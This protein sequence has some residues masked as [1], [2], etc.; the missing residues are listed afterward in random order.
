[1]PP[2]RRAAEATAPSPVSGLS[3]GIGAIQFS[4][5]DSCSQGSVFV[6]SQGSILAGD[7]N[8]HSQD[9]FRSQS[10]SQ[11]YSQPEYF[12]GDFCTP[13]DQ[14]ADLGWSQEDGGAENAEP[15][16]STKSASKMCPPTPDVT[17]KRRKTRS[18]SPRRPRTS[19]FTYD[20]D[21][22]QE[23]EE[24]EED[25]ASDVKNEQQPRLLGGDTRRSK[26]EAAGKKSP[27]VAPSK[28]RGGTKKLQGK[29]NSRGVGS[30]LITAYMSQ[31]SVPA[32]AG[33]SSSPSG[34]EGDGMRDSLSPMGGALFGPKGSKE[35]REGCRRLSASGTKIG[36]KACRRNP[37]LAC[38]L[39]EKERK[40]P[41]RALPRLDKGAR[42]TRYLQDF[43]EL[44]VLGQGNFGCVYLARSRID[45]QTYAV[46]R[47][48]SG[49][50]DAAELTKQ[51]ERAMREV[52]AMAA[53]AHLPYVVRY[54]TSWRENSQLF[55][56]MEACECHIKERY[57][58]KHPHAAILL[59]LIAQIGSA[60]A[61][62]HSMGLAHLDVKP[63]NIYCSGND[64]R[65]GDFGLVCS[66]VCG[67][68]DCIYLFMTYIALFICL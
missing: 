6:G 61:G 55:I 14:V 52:W 11:Q 47:K 9:S 62:M 48:D 40:T 42:A 36:A 27:P 3:C 16:R 28:P 34:V 65:L 20:L 63:D 1:M 33:A 26:L 30:N 23:G 57:L 66:Q 44:S 46:K 25:V 67:V 5:Q 32:S 13:E 17:S 68:S 51:E 53:I 60:L 18:K 50:D 45:G 12:S 38:G 49:G 43:E 19:K 10:Q 64:F 31:E 58:F 37:F 39:T 4:S 7:H 8:M 59:R 15:N 35:G 41:S 24:D 21:A 22:L 2:K 29:Q 54:Q 56:Q